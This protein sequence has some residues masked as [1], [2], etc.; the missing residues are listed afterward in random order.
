MRYRATEAPVVGYTNTDEVVLFTI[1]L[2]FFVGI[3]LTWMG[4]KGRQ[5]WLLVCGVP[6]TLVSAIYLLWSTL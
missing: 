3:A 6:L 2:S 5:V 4:V 1:A